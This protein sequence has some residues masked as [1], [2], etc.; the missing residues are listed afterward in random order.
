MRAPI[1]VGDIVK[2]KGSKKVKSAP[3]GVVIQTFEKDPHFVSVECIVEWF[4]D[5]R[6]EKL[7]TSQL[8]RITLDHL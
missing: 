8:S 6:R 2:M 1:S 5:A 7:F 4:N 3:V